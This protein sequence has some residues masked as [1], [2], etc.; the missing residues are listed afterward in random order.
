[1]MTSYASSFFIPTPYRHHGVAISHLMF[2]DDVVVFSK[3]TP[4]AA[5]NLRNFLQ[6]FKRFSG[7]G[8]NWMNSSMFFS[9]CLNEDMA[10]ISCSV[11]IQVGS[12][13]IRYLGISLLRE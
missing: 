13:P 12:L 3:A 9:N 2:D 1:M 10:I 5:Y 8:V 6:Q 4:S 11:Q 7:L